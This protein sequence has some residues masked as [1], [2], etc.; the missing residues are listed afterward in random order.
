MKRHYF[1]NPFSET[2][3]RT[4]YAN[5]PNDTWGDL[6]I[7]VVQDV[8]GPKGYNKPALMS[9]SDIEQLTEYI[10]DFKFVPGG[11]YLWYAGRKNHY[12]NNCGGGNTKLLTDKGWVV[13]KDVVN[14]II[15][16]LSPI[17][18]KYYP[19]VMYEHGEQELN[20]ITFVPLRGQSQIEYKVNFTRTH[21]WPLIDGSDTYD[22]R[23]GDV[24]PANMFSSPESSLGFVHGFMFGD[25]T[26]NGKLRL[27]KPKYKYLG[28]LLSVPHTISYPVSNKGDPYISYIND[29]NWKEFPITTDAAY[30]ASF[31][32]GWIAADGCQVGNSIHSISKENLEW[33][34]NH[35]AYAGIVITGDLRKQIRD[36]KIGKYNYKDHII[37]IQNFQYGSDWSGFKV[38]TIKSIGVQKV[39]CP[40]EPIFN[41]IIIDH[42]IDTYQCYL[43]RAEYDTREEW[44]DLT[45]RAVNCL[46]TGGGIGIDYSIL[47]PEGRLLSRTGGL[48]S[49]P[50]PLMQM[51]NEVG[52]GVMQGGSRRS[53]I[54]ASL[55]W[56]HEDIPNFLKAKN[57]TEQVRSI[58]E[59]DF[60]FPAP[61]D[62][63]N[64]SVNY[65]DA[66]FGSLTG[67][68]T[69]FPK[70]YPSE[71]LATNPIFL[72][73]CKQ[74]MKTGEPGF[75]FN[76]GDKQNETLRNAC[77]EVTSEDDSD[78]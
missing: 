40:F 42:N 53:A 31:I 47:R 35:A 32:H 59:Q 4:K 22:L 65:D 27:C 58:K 26:V 60:N 43:L 10:K 71:V 2:I 1:K 52:R 15:N 5:G 41:R 75:S 56:Q 29:I 12:F 25:G 37:Y 19:A 46:M 28:K 45:K 21:R 51:I 16:V 14:K 49:G 48:S 62:M 57:W 61:L 18:G 3:F 30:I 24:V 69:G 8:C 9:S 38:K 77:T 64:I 67:G 13:F 78:V 7:R 20:E 66:A 36:V 54:Y 76:F 44:A 74:A 72:E 50:I 34:R 63:T 55:N 23:V 39:Y 73:N 68:S 17:D 6:A 11:R 70:T 33:F